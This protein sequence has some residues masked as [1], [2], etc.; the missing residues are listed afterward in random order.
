[1]ESV[2]ITFLLNVIHGFFSLIYYGAV[3]AFAILLPRLPKLSESTVYEL[4][5]LILPTFLSFIQTSG[6][7]TIVFGAGEF[8]FY[9]IGYYKAGGFAEVSYILFSTGWGICVFSGAI[10][11]FIGFSVGLFI[12]RNLE[13]LF[14]LY[15]LTDPSTIYEIKQILARL[16][17]YSTLGAGFLTIAVILMVL[18]VSFLPLPK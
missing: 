14:K 3:V 9:M 16:S 10:I 17:F 13:R 6:M 12:A 11:G 18:A 8:L 5:T 15:R 7:I 1:M 4:M 2:P